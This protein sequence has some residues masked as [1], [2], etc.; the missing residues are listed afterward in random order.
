MVMTSSQNLVVLFVAAL[1]LIHAVSVL[2]TLP[3]KRSFAALGCMGIY[4]KAKFAR[5]SR[6]CEECYN[7]YREPFIAKECRSNCFK[8]DM[9][10]DCLKVLLMNNEEDDLLQMANAVYGKRK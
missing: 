1:V 2:S 6:V 8:N 4:D 10:N 3:E 7:V 5:L 9:F